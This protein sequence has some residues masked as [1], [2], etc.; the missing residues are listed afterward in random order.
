M[1]LIRLFLVVLL[2][3]GCG[4][5]SGGGSASGNNK[6][7]DPV[8]NIIPAPV[9]RPPEL[10]CLYNERNCS[11]ADV[12]LDAPVI[13]A[14]DNGISIVHIRWARCSSDEAAKYAYD[15]GVTIICLAGD[16]G[17]EITENSPYTITVGSRALYSNYGPGVDVVLLNNGTIHSGIL[18]TALIATGQELEDHSFPDEPWISHETV[19]I[20]DNGFDFIRPEYV[21]YKNEMLVGEVTGDYGVKA[22][23]E[24]FRYVKVP[25]I[26]YVPF[27][28][29]PANPRIDNWVVGNLTG[30]IT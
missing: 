1:A 30:D 2:L 23:N 26:G 27:N 3:Y 17:R 20:V 29:K 22:L 28:K 14:A 13:W 7:S 8:A 25:V 19:M 21:L 15:R 16:D 4:S 10:S 6:V 9:V 24:L 18:A 11:D 5:G 12:D